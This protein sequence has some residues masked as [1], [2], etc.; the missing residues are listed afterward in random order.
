MNSFGGMPQKL[1]HDLMFLRSEITTTN[2]INSFG[3]MP[4]K[5]CADESANKE[6]EVGGCSCVLAAI[7]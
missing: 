7:V 4:L 1:M 6:H 5:V 3:G 2:S